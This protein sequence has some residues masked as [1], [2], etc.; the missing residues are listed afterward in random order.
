MCARN[1]FAGMN[2]SWHVAELPVHF[3]FSM[4]RENRYK[5]S[6]SLI[7]D[8]F[9]AKIYFI[10]FKKECPRISDVVKKMVSKV[11]QWYLDECDTYIR[12][13]GA[14]DDPKRYFT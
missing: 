3:Y 13:F 5:K 9:I 14:T 4:L 1:I 2:L 12:V 6:Y 7:Y 8:E 10:P 11:C